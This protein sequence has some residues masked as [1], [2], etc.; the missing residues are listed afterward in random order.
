MNITAQ[1]SQ[2]I[3]SYYKREIQKRNSHG[4]I[5][6]V[7]VTHIYSCFEYQSMKKILIVLVN[8]SMYLNLQ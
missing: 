7:L 1:N 3:K 2:V 8:C 6:P 5:G 4:V